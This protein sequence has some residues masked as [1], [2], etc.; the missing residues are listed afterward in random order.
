MSSEQRFSFHKDFQSLQQKR[1]PKVGG[2]GVIP[3][4]NLSNANSIEIKTPS[5]INILDNN[6]KRDS[7]FKRASDSSPSNHYSSSGSNLSSITSKAELLREELDHL[8]DSLIADSTPIRQTISS[9]QSTFG[10]KSKYNDVFHNSVDLSELLSD[11]IEPKYSMDLESLKINNKSSIER[12][13][14]NL[15]LQVSF[16]GMFIYFTNY[17]RIIDGTIIKSK[18]HLSNIIF[19][20][21]FFI[22]EMKNYK[23]FI[24]VKPLEQNHFREFIKDS[25]IWPIEPKT[26][27]PKE[28]E[29]Y[30][31]QLTQACQFSDQTFKSDTRLTPLSTKT[32]FSPDLR[33]TRSKARSE[34]F[35]NLG[36]SHKEPISISEPSQTSNILSSFRNNNLRR[37]TKPSIIDDEITV[38]ETPA[39]FSPDLKYRFAHNKLVTITYS[40]FKTLYNNDWINDSVIDFFIQYEIDKV[41]HQYKLLQA[42]DI[43]AL[44]SFFFTKLMYKSNIQETPDYYGNIKRWLTK[45]DIMNYPYVIIPI[46]ENAHWYCCV[47]KGL[48][49]LLEKGLADKKAKE[50]NRIIIPDSQDYQ[51]FNFEAYKA[52]I[53][54]DDDS[55]DDRDRDQDYNDANTESPKPNDTNGGVPNNNSK[56][57]AVKKFQTEIFVFDSLAQTH[58]NI[59]FPIKKFIIDY[60]ADKYGIEIAKQQLRVINAR[61]PKQSNFNDCGIHVIYNVKTWL[62][63]IADCERIWKGH[64]SNR[65][66]GGRRSIFVAEERNNTRKQL[67]DILL[68]LHKEQSLTQIEVNNGG[69]DSDDDLEVIECTPEVEDK[70]KKDSQDQTLT[71]KPVEPEKHV[72]RETQVG[73][74]TP[75]V[76]NSQTIVNRSPVEYPTTLD[77]RAQPKERF[78]NVTLNKKLEGRELDD[79]VVR[80]LNE[81]FDKKNREIGPVLLEVVTDM[82]QDLLEFDPDSDKGIARLRAFK[83]DYELH[84][85][86]QGES[87]RPKH[88]E[89]RIDPNIEPFNTSRD[90]DSDD[91]NESVSKLKISSKSP[92]DKSNSILKEFDGRKTPDPIP[93]FKGRSISK[94][95]PKH[96]KSPTPVGSRSVSST[97]TRSPS[98]GRRATSTPIETITIVDTVDVQSKPNGYVS[99]GRKSKSNGFGRLSRKE[100]KRRRIN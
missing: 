78:I 90:N 71:N 66:G 22:F 23:G 48:P 4:N 34:A 89:F 43:Y 59:S 96:W 73:S 37:P 85:K 82:C 20:K 58:S 86:Q 9:S 8:P 61:V 91:V 19:S 42:E 6:V 17:N 29:K 81:L 5:R 1:R 80:F 46:N 24:L 74:E 3:I 53:E 55:D 76:E 21:S 50:L 75:I 10:Q 60:C 57:Q 100:S 63:N 7:T 14:N 65:G 11:D 32:F 77:P 84:S 13:S 54:N 40:D 47:I 12:G 31:S 69:P 45:V 38:K 52:R 94:E 15:K 26:F 72:E 93:L 92:I 64:S 16:N 68:K 25:T 62:N 39:P 27:T 28:A 79:S 30:I 97:S 99:P 2:V 41:V 51:E 44:N 70:P 35:G 95:L 67:I 18:G 87:T 36:G 33:S 49:N 98:S 83:D 56:N 88:Q